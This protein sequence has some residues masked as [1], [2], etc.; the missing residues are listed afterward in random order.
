MYLVEA[1]SDRPELLPALAV[2]I[3]AALEAA[4]HADAQVEVFI[5][6]GALPTYQR[7]ALGFAALL[8]AA[9]P[10]AEIRLATV[11]DTWTEEHGP[12]FDAE[13]P[14]LD[15]D[16]RTRV[17]AYL[18]GGT[19]L[20]SAPEHA[21]DVLSPERH[22][23]VPTVCRTDGTWIWTDAVAYYLREHGLAPDRELL[24]HI[25]AVGYARP[26]VDAVAAHRALSVLYAEAD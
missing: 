13:H 15:G 24:W 5:D 23:V 11:Y 17:L 14:G 1:G 22:G 7:T 3:G 26:V 21:D 6:P 16:D 12:G 4:G 2:Q 8:W 18:D 9:T 20:L 25:R 10:R 19:A